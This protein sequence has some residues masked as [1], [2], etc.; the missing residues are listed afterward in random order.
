MKLI[1]SIDTEEDDWSNYHSTGYSLENIREIPR[2]QDLFD[3]FGVKPTYLVTYS[4]AADMHAVALLKTIMDE[5]LCEIGTHCHPWNTP[6]FIEEITSR[7]SMLCNLPADLQ[8]KKLRNLHE[9]ITNNFGIVPVSFRA[10]RWG[11]NRDV[12][13]NLRSLGYKIDTSI[14]PYTDW[15]GYHGPDFS[16]VPPGPYRFSCGDVL[17][18][19]PAGEMVEIPA[20]IGFLQQNFALCNSILKAA[21]RFPIKYLRPIG[22]LY[23]IRVVNKVWLSPEVADGKTMIKLARR[24]MRNSYPVI[25]MVFHSP[26]LKAGLTPFVR[27]RGDERRFIGHIKEFLTFV[28]DTGIRPITL[29]EVL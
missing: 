16:G 13:R 21:K 23:R 10:G 15:T 18:R 7:N 26:A 2:L 11:Y 28:Q 9:T 6:P 8:Y 29:S 4:V 3:K 27:T 25:N 1:I 14:T 12:A 20:T 22:I 19:A 17:R 24:M 5:G